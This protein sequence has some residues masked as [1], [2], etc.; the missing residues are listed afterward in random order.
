MIYVYYYIEKNTKFLVPRRV[1]ANERSRLQTRK[2][3]EPKI[4]YVSGV[5]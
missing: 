2:R 3:Q 5:L 4:E 1:S